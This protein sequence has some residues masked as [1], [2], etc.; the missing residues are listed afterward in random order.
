MFIADEIQT[1]FC[2]T[3]DWFACEH[4][5]VV[6]DLITLAKGMAG[7]L[8]LAAVTGRAELMDAVHPG[9]L[10]GTY[11]G[12]PVA[13]A[14]ALG[15]I[16]TMRELDLAGAARA[17]G[18]TMLP[19]LR[20]LAERVPGDRRR[21]RARRDDR[22]RAGPAGHHEPDAALTAAVAK[23][24]H[25]E[26]V[27]VLTAGTY[28]NVLRFLPPLV[29]GQDLLAEAL[30]VIEAAFD[31]RLTRATSR[32]LAAETRRPPWR[33]PAASSST[34]RRFSAS[35]WSGWPITPPVESP[36]CSAAALP[37]RTCVGSASVDLDA[38]AVERARQA[39]EF[40]VRT[41]ATRAV[42]GR[43]TG[44]GANR[45]AVIDP[46][47]A[48]EHGLRLLRSHAGGTGDPLPD[49]V[50]RAADA[51]PAQPARGRRQRRPPA[52]AGR[53]GRRPCGS[54]RC[55]WCTRGAPSAPVT[56]PRW[57]RSR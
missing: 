7:G 56:S 1:G 38:A 5:G 43:T 50:V 31:R 10:G 4:E 53:P 34:A 9:G 40:A 45:D 42:Y 47:A 51:D 36:P 55:R 8:P 30:D 25:A 14:A 22:P 17:I 15:A 57:P 28:G 48:D 52:A 13:C 23:R 20:A 49:A 35:T 3:G 39:Y 41:G 18:A 54:G 46:Q 6:P 29:I 11:G 12:N 33:T 26:G 2:R 19:R 27:V 21:A 16:E 37:G 32:T 24:C 44:V